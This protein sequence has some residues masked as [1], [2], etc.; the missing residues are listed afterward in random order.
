LHLKLHA[1]NAVLSCCISPG[2]R[3]GL[4]IANDT[5]LVY[6][7]TPLLIA[8]PSNKP[9]AIRLDTAAIPIELSQDGIILCPRFN[10]QPY[11]ITRTSW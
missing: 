10:I 4:L 2:I 8:E 6:A 1:R 3:I 11:K 5:T 7:P 9:N